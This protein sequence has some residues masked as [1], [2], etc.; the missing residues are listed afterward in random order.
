LHGAA[1]WHWGPQAQA[2]WLPACWQPQV[3]A[4]P[5]QLAHWQFGL[6]VEVMAF[7]CSG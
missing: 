5:G 4:L 1:H 3:Q 2:C 6:V 7:S